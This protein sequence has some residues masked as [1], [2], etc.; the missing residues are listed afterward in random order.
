MILVPQNIC[1]SVF[2]GSHNLAL[3]H[4][5]KDNKWKALNEK[6]GTYIVHHLQC[7]GAFVEKHE[8][9]VCLK[10]CQMWQTTTGHDSAQL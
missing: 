6:E 4:E 10:H 7:Y 3:T 8:I 1:G 5:S 9:P 2:I